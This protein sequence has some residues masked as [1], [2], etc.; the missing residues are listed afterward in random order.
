MNDK[1][2]ILQGYL[3][4]GFYIGYQDGLWQLFAKDG[5]SVA[6]GATLRG[7][8]CQLPDLDQ[9]EWYASS[10]EQAASTFAESAMKVANALYHEKV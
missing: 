4:N 8:V 3:I 5:D 6:Q 1:I 10:L 2:D 9:A 7:M